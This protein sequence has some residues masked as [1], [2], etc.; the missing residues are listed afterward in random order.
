MTL[1]DR[2]SI[3]SGVMNL[4]AP[5]KRLA[6][7][8]ALVEGN[9]IRSIERLTGVHRDTIMRLMVR[10][11][12]GCADL[13]DTKLRNLPCKRVQVDEIWTFV[14]VKERRMNGVHNHAE[15]GDQYVFVA[16]DA[17]TKLVV[18]H[19]VGKRD[20]PNTYR[21]VADLKERLAN[22]VQ[23]T[24]DG[25]T[26]YR[27]AVEDVFGIDIEFAQLVKLYGQERKKSEDRDWYTPVR[28][29][30]AIPM[31]MMGKPDPWKI[32]TS[33]IERQNLTMRMQMRRLTRLTNGF[34][35]KLEN[36]KAA[37]AL[38]FAHYNF[39]RVHTTL[40]VT[41]AMATQLTDHIWSMEELLAAAI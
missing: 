19:L 1:L 24:T 27:T 16:I 6:V 8:A 5:E 28:V 9:S 15:M 18:S 14:F 23:L 7:L 21:F 39:C 34:S 33:Y 30:A 20:V 17:D 29:M 26:A 3:V 10:A 41:P 38:H 4:L 22:R 11:G 25:F 31:R 35:K 2:S 37:V 13:L 36:L 40:R 12:L 32:S